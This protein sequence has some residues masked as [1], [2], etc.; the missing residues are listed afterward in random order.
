VH[1]GGRLA[2]LEGGAGDD[3]DLALLLQ[4][5]EL[6]VR[7]QGAVGL[8]HRRLGI[9]VRDEERV[10]LK[11]LRIHVGQRRPRSTRRCTVSRASMW[12]TIPSTGTC[13]Y[14]STSSMVP[15][16]VSSVSCTKARTR[17]SMRPTS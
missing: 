6:D 15:M 8:G 3:E 16:D 14:V 4:A 13:R 5:R 10:A 7:A 17:P 9:E 11:R 12:G 2:F 1:D